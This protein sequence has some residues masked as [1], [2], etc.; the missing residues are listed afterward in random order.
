VGLA[1]GGL[2]V[3]FKQGH[4]NFAMSTCLFCGPTILVCF[5]YRGLLLRQ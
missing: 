2:D 3:E 1:I 4:R 5:G